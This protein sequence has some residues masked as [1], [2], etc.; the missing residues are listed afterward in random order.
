MPPLTT[1]EQII[2]AKLQKESLYLRLDEQLVSMASSHAAKIPQV[3]E[4]LDKV[5]NFPDAVRWELKESGLPA[6]EIEHEL[7]SQLAYYQWKKAR[8][9]EVVSLISSEQEFRADG[10]VD[11]TQV[12]AEQAAR[13]AVEEQR[14][15]DHREARGLPPR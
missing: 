1:A 8:L 11:R 12:Q 3:L 7:S 2:E 6:D 14:I 13:E 5:T 4:D 10:K 9:E 15:A